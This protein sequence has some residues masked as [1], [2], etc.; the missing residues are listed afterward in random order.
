[1]GLVRKGISV[2]H[3][4]ET[5]YAQE[6]LLQNM[7]EDLDFRQMQHVNLFCE[8]ESLMILKRQ[9]QRRAQKGI[10]FIGSGN[11]HY[12]TYLLLKEMTEP[13]TLVLFDN[14]PDLG[15]GQNRGE[16]LLSCGSWVSYALKKIPLLQRVVIIGPTTIS[17]HQI[18]HP[19]VVILPFD[20]RHH[21]SLKSILSLIHT[22]HVYISIDKDV[23][24]KD[25]VATNWDQGIMNLNTLTH[26][27]KTI[28]THKQIEGVD[29]CGEEYISPVDMLLPDYQTIIHK[30]ELA[31]MAILQTCLNASRQQTKGA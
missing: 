17:Q 28:I 9:L 27:L 24:T 10:T 8:E 21:Y 23:L 25:E 12:M 26:Y 7:H 29:I 18:H 20:G 13:F 11:Y 16:G 1:M 19:Q 5:Y 14:H 30:N 31:N 22:Q 6:K 3:F 15:T 2:I 4:D